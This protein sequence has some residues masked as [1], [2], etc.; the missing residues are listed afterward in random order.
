MPKPHGREPTGIV[1]TFSK[2]SFVDRKVEE[3]FFPNREKSFRL[4]F[5]DPEGKEFSLG[6]ERG[7][8]PLCGRPHEGHLP[9]RPAR[10]PGLGD[11][12]KQRHE[13][14]QIPVE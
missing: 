2:P 1:E 5:A 12:A 9:E 14:F 7:S 3:R 11:P 13:P 8:G 4:A 10:L 6:L